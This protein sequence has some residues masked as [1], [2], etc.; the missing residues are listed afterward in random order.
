MTI[1]R[2]HKILSAAIARGEGRCRVFVFKTTFSHN[3]ESDGCVILDVDSADM[4]MVYLTDDDGGIAQTKR[5]Q[6][7]TL[8]AMILC[9]EDGRGVFEEEK[10]AAKGGA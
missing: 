6:E 8:Y 3:C 9:G 1:N 10:D 5:G 7:R 4:E 2:L